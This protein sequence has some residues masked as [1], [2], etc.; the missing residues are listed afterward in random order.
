MQ[1]T[2]FQLQN[3]K[4]IMDRIKAVAFTDSVHSLAHQRADKKLLQ[5][6]KR[7]LEH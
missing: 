2:L 6:M 1:L 4:G 3:C 5:W 7:V